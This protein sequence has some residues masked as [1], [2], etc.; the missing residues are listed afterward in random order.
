MDRYKRKLTII[1][2]LCILAGIAVAS[3]LLIMGYYDYPSADDWAVSVDTRQIVLSGGSILA[4]L[5]QAVIEAV[6]WWKG[7][8][9]RYMN[10]FFSAL[11]PGIWGEHF[12]G[13]TPWLMI[14]S[15]I[16]S[17]LFLAFFLLYDAGQKNAKWILPAMIPSLLLQL[18]Y[19]PYPDETFY[20]YSGAVNY[21]FVFSLSLILACIFFR[22][23]RG[24]MSR[25]KTAG[26][27]A[28]GILLS[29]VV[30][31]DSY[32]ASLSTV[33]VFALASLFFLWKDRRALLR[34][35]PMT[36][37]TLAG[38]VVCLLSPA[39]RVRM[40]NEL[41]GTTN[42]IWK[43]VWMSLSRSATN[44]YS[45][46][47]W[48]IVLMVLLALPFLWKLLKRHRGGFRYP[49][50]FTAVTFG[51][52]ASQTTA[53]MY[54]EQGVSAKR[55]ADVLYYTYHIWVLFNVGYWV[56]WLQ[57]RTRLSSHK[58]WEGFRV[59][60]KGHLMTWFCI[61]GILLAGVMGMTDLKDSSTARA[62]IW[63][64]KGQAEDYGR[65]WEER[66]AVLHDESVT[67][68]YFDPLPWRE[69]MVFYTDFKPGDSWVNNACAQY[70][71]KDHVGLK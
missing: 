45:W 4:L 34:T 48:K 20:W 5:K 38:L 29:V 47:N 27:L 30:G 6:N 19:V 42:G 8:E 36:M 53:N 13:I 44:I 49:V 11:Q 54:V 32:S 55:I 69:E 64:F 66:F 33:C 1:N 12:Y 56:G 23:A 60:M 7:S 24:G 68:V 18:L 2:V 17:E 3:P 35:L 43:A 16:F 14:G 62:C 28:F 59:W 15:L 50:L 26:M 58:A 21:T 40:E 41:S 51:I 67:E 9:P 39:N 31:G 46:S 57:R 61:L 71:G 65:A 25:G 37:V 63:L 10:T 52:Y 22:V 70:Y